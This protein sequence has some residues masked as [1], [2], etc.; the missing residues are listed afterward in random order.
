[1]TLNDEQG[2]HKGLGFTR[3]DYI[4]AFPQEL[5]ILLHLQERDTVKCCPVPCTADGQEYLSKRF[6]VSLTFAFHCLRNK[7]AAPYDWNNVINERR[8]DYKSFL[9]S[10]M[11]Q[12]EIIRLCAFTLV[13]AE[14]V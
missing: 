14:L 4:W 9:R 11:G 13:I 10:P 1:M 7:P 6:N 3:Q 12:M 2:F 5:E 8:N